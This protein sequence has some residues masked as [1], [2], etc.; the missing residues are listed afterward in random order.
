MLCS[1]CPLVIDSNSTTAT[2]LAA[3]NDHDQDP[4]KCNLSPTKEPRMPDLQ[5]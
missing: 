5:T 4:D 2:A 3:A 1:A